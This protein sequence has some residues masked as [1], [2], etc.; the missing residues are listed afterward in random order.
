MSDI[1]YLDIGGTVFKTTRSNLRKIPYF[2]E[3]LEDLDANGDHRT[4]SKAYP[5]FIDRDPEHFKHVINYVRDRYYTIPEESLHEFK[6]FGFHIDD[7]KISGAHQHVELQQSPNMFHTVRDEYY[8][9][10]FHHHSQNKG[11]YRLYQMTGEDFTSLP[12]TCT[13]EPNDMV[14]NFHLILPKHCQLSDFTV[15]IRVKNRNQYEYNLEITPYLYREQVRHAGDQQY[16]PIFFH[17]TL[18]LTAFSVIEI[19]LSSARFHTLDTGIRY[20][21]TVID[22]NYKIQL[23]KDKQPCFM[24]KIHQQ[25]VNGTEVVLPHNKYIRFVVWETEP[26]ADSITLQVNKHQRVIPKMDF[27]SWERFRVGM[28]PLPEG[29]GCI[30]WCSD[31]TDHHKKSHGFVISGEHSRASLTFPT[32]TRKIKLWTFTVELLH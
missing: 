10:K 9:S 12:W 11:D 19:T 5:L 16:V 1:M 32:K 18:G 25:T 20:E 22:P 30:Y 31:P 3:R 2:R 8:N 28:E 23:F 21:E 24:T 7:G 13:V 17:H 15:G 29:W 4:G 14:G 27:T 26:V 6:F